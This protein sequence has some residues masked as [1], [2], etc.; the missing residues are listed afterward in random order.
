M[1]VG[2][3]NEGLLIALDVQLYSNGGAV[4]DTSTAV[5]HD[6]ILIVSFV[7]IIVQST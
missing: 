7:S 4:V 5:R 6:L 1:Q 2:F 3:T